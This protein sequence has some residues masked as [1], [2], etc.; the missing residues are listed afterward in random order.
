[1]QQIMPNLTVF[2]Q[3]II[4]LVALIVVKRFILNP[5]S[6]VLKGR[7]DRI[8]GAEQQAK[9][10]V[11]ESAALDQQ[12]KKRIRDGRAR[13][14]EEKNR[15]RQE[16]LGVEREILEK[17]RLEAQD[18]LLKIREE[19]RRESEQAR[20][21]LQ[22]EAAGLSQTMAEKILGRPLHETQRHG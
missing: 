1:M 16:S 14:Q 5:I 11:E 8:E 20:V 22:R 21:R 12:Y 15:R 10:L 13:A 6:D 19:I 18:Y 2:I 17:A 9:R 7:T 3:A 4:F